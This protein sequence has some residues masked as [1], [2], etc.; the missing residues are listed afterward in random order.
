MSTSTR[1]QVYTRSDKGIT[2]S[3]PTLPECTVVVRTNRGKKKIQGNV[4]PNYVTEI[5]LNDTVP[6]QINGI[7]ST[8]AV[9]FRVRISSDKESMWRA[10]DLA[11][12][13]VA[14]LNDWLDQN[15]PLGFEMREPPISIPRSA[16]TEAGNPASGT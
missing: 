1:M 2:Y 10:K 3:D 9:S 12:S 14:Q 6:V 16:K 11:R 7:T 13:V 15:V 8:D 4:V 5:I